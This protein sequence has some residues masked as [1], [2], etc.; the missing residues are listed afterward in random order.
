MASKKGIK[1][2]VNAR[3]SDVAEVAEAIKALVKKHAVDLKVGYIDGDD[4]ADAVSDAHYNSKYLEV[5]RILL[6]A[7]CIRCESFSWRCNMVA[8]ID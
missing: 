8:Y 6:S 4:E 1:L 7:V 3:A 5:T 2:A